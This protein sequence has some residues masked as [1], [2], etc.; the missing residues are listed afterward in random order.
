M[1]M[2]KCDLAWQDGWRNRQE[3]TREFHRPD[4]DAVR[5]AVV[6]DVFEFDF[7]FDFVV[8]EAKKLEPL[9]IK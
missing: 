7:Y 3:L 4:W 8:S 9:W 5:D 2:F 6:G 1:I